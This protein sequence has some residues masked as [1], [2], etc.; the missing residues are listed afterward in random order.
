MPSRK[1]WIASWN[2]ENQAPSDDLLNNHFIKKEFT[3]NN[4]GDDGDRRAMP[5]VIII[6]LQEA[7]PHNK[8]YVGER[9]VDI[10][11]KE[12]ASKDS[13]GNTTTAPIY[14]ELTKLS[15]SGFTKGTTNYM[16]I[17]CLVKRHMAS[18]YTNV[19][20]TSYKDGIEGKGGVCISFTTE[21]ARFGFAGCHLDSKKASN[22]NDQI[23]KV[24]KRLSG[25]PKG[26]HASVGDI[27]QALDA[28]YHAVFMT[29]DLNYRLRPSQDITLDW[30]PWDLAD[31][32]ADPARRDELWALDTLN[33]TMFID[34]KA[35]DEDKAL[36][37]GQ[38]LV[39]KPTDSPA[40][41]GFIF[42]KPAPLFLPSY[43]I[44]YK[45]DDAQN[46]WLRINSQ[47]AGVQDVADCYF[48][49]KHKGEVLYDAKSSRPG[50]FELGWLDRVGYRL[51]PNN[52]P[53]VTVDEFKNFEGFKLADHAPVM[54]KLTVSW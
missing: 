23:R 52:P 51:R 9:L 54:M 14:K 34:T 41:F 31:L 26:D 35:K 36:L 25:S 1:I 37:G 2:C 40:G 30:D 6:A 53:T 42:P 17:S 48:K 8:K 47:N 3:D 28:N 39:N 46:P 43:K 21:G 24:M 38:R 33:D 22:R 19:T 10:L 44:D 18:A 16:Q 49:R 20:T 15:Q 13:H 27:N 4:W 32:I 45:T 12:T 11:P 29:G 7:K 50:L 5:D